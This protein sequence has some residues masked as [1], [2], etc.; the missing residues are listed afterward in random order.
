MLVL[1]LKA[2][3]VFAG[4]WLVA[5]LIGRYVALAKAEQATDLAALRAVMPVASV[6][7]QRMVIPGFTAV[8]AAGLATAWTE[9]WPILGFM[10]GGRSNWV[11]V[12]L[13]LFLAIN[14][15]VVFVFVPRGKIFERAMREA[16]VQ[17]RVTPALTAASHDPVVRAAHYCELVVVALIIAL[18]VLKP[19]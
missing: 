9:G 1:I 3:H 16:I 2:L 18:M 7:E 10:Q 11:L 19:F 4:F 17:G 12:S 5:G 15:L 8:L 14:L 6:F 13:V